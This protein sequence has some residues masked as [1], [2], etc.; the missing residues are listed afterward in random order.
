MKRHLLTISVTVIAYRRPTYLRRCLRSLITQNRKP[1]EII[2]VS[3]KEDIESQNVINCIKKDSPIV[4]NVF[5]EY[6]A[7]S[8]VPEAMLARN[9]CIESASGQVICFI[10]DDSIATPEWIERIE[11]YF[12]QDEI[13]GVGGPCP[14]PERG[15]SVAN[16]ID[17]VL[18]VSSFGAVGIYGGEYFVPKTI[19]VDHLQGT[20]MSFKRELLERFDE[21]LVGHTSR[22]DM[23]VCLSIRKKGYKIIYDPQIIVYHYYDS[24]P[25]LH[26]DRKEK[27]GRIREMN[28]NTTYVLLKHLG[29]PKQIVFLL[30]TFVIGDTQ[31][32]G[33]LR[34][35]IRAVR[36]RRTEDVTKFLLP[37]LKGKLQGVLLYLRCRNKGTNMLQ[38]MPKCKIC[39]DNNGVRFKFKIYNQSFRE[40]GE[41]CYYCKQCDF[42]FIHPVPNIEVLKAQYD[43]HGEV[44]YKKF[45]L[46]GDFSKE[47]ELSHGK[48]LRII[49]NIKPHGRLCEIGCATGGFLVAAKNWG[50]DVAGVEISE[51]MAKYGKDEVGLDIRAGTIYD[52]QFPRESFDVVYSWHCLE[53]TPDFNEVVA[54]IYRILKPGGVLMLGVPNGRFIMTRLMG[55]K[56]RHVAAGHLSYFSPLSIRKIMK[57]QGFNVRKIR[58]YGFDKFT[59]FWD[60]GII[61]DKNL[62]DYG[63]YR[64]LISR[65]N[66]LWKKPY[67]LPIRLPL[68]FFRPIVARFG[69]GENL[70]CIA[71]K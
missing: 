70:I 56:C 4:K 20:N 24:S 18:Q 59:L 49:S 5:L 53:H 71:T 40:E 10:D 43:Y 9:K 37:A 65:V 32:P 12:Y 62:S 67:M 52:A 23:D 35:L 64:D 27:Y 16:K 14:N 38:K 55:I 2:V 28:I 26:P 44:V 25:C 8:S 41:D 50:F 1:Q 42:M 17:E 57:K 63:E 47:A 45:R 51:P 68:I 54:E 7:E 46:R 13:G 3:K 48:H 31:T 15:R 61:S 29:L 66:N 30:F 60:L 69:R 58:T 36:N 39:E 19:E 33:V 6:P 21:N 11:P 34:N 22:D